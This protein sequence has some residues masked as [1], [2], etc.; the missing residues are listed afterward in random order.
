MYVMMHRVLAE[1]A[2]RSLLVKKVIAVTWGQTRLG[3]EIEHVC[4][5]TREAKAV[6]ILIF[7]VEYLFNDTLV[8]RPQFIGQ[9]FG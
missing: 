7:L 8:C 4:I 1:S 6:I 3:K 2:L 9:L 5:I